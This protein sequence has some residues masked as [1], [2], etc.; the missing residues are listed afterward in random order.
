MKK[1]V[2]FTAVFLMMLTMAGCASGSNSSD[3]ASS[4]RLY[5]PKSSPAEV[6]FGGETRVR[7]NLWT[8]QR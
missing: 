4:R 8:Q 5:A 1:L 3:G 6:S 7:S 2:A